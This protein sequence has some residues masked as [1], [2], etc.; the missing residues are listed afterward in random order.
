MMQK[1]VQYNVE[2]F[3]AEI[4]VQNILKCFISESLK[5]FLGTIIYSNSTILLS[6]T[7]HA[8][9]HFTNTNPPSYSPF[10]CPIPRV[11]IVQHRNLII[12]WDQLSHG[13]IQF[14]SLPGRLKETEWLSVQDSVIHARGMLREFQKA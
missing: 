2:Y 10:S 6:L 12:F 13:P 1:L 8:L 14:P 3:Q 5:Y 4:H 11:R 9:T 7:F